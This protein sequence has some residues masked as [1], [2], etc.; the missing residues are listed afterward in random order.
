LGYTVGTLEHY[1]RISDREE[2]RVACIKDK[3]I[4]PVTLNCDYSLTRFNKLEELS[5]RFDFMKY[6][7]HMPFKEPWYIEK[8]YFN[9]PMYT[10]DVFGIENKNHEIKTLLIAREQNCNG[11]KILR[12]VDCIGESNYIKYIS[13]DIQ[14][15]IDE[16]GYE[17]V[18][19]Y[20]HGIEKEIMEQAGFS[21]KSDTGNIIPNYFEPFVLEN[22]EIN[23]FTTDN[24]GFAVFKGDADQDRPSLIKG[25]KP[26]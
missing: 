9:H 25:S 24:E 10:Y 19:F 21:L 5:V 4:F 13:V 20:Q 16:R 3:R 11:V 7:D 2:Y 26:V 12:F 18:D 23:Y 22:I 14:R 17:Y 1:Y 8:R 6:K 15:L